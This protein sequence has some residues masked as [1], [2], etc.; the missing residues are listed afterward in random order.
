MLAKNISS[1]V[2]D[3]RE[4]EI[5]KIENFLTEGRMNPDDI[6][7]LTTETLNMD[8][9]LKPEQIKDLV[10]KI[11]N[12]LHSL[13][14]IDDIIKETSPSLKQAKTLKKNADE[15][16]IKANEFLNSATLVIKALDDTE[17]A[18]TKAKSAIMTAHADIESAEENL[19]EITK[20]RSIA[21]EKA[22]LTAQRVKNLQTNLVRLQENVLKNN[23]YATELTRNAQAVGESA[24][25]SDNQAMKLQ[26]EYERVNKTLIEKSNRSHKSR[27]KANEL[28]NRAMKLNGD[29]VHKLKMLNGKF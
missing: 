21:Q 5:K 4:Q 24:E 17:D 15:A 13:T 6:Y 27:D 22:N 14:N 2:F 29:T 10:A 20:E 16:K 25:A 18:Q 26:E 11:K 9:K 28:K 1:D 12:T 23:L 7:K 19:I 3:E 8:I